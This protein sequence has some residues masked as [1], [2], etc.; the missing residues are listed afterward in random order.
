MSRREPTSAER[1]IGGGSTKRG[2]VADSGALKKKELLFATHR[3]WIWAVGIRS[4]YYE[5]L[6]ANPPSSGD[7]LEWFLTGEA[8]YLCIW[9]GLLFTVAKGY[10]KTDSWYPTH[11]PK[12][13]QSTILCGCSGTPFS[14]SRQNIDLEDILFSSRP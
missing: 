2:T 5:R 1:Q 10:A 3:H 11:K 6:K 9:Y 12:S 7:L 4:E 14:T 13:M 8:M